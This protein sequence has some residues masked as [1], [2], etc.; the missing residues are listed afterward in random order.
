MYGDQGGGRSGTL[1]RSAR[2]LPERVRL[3]DG[4]VSCVSC[5]DLYETEPRRLA[6]SMEKSEL[7]LTCHD[8]K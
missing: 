7:C 3:P 4:K 1:L 6:V 2:L 8:K 5:H